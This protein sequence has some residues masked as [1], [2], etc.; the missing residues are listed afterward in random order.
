MQRQDCFYRAL[1]F[2]HAKAGFWGDSGIEA[3]VKFTYLPA[4]S[5]PMIK[6]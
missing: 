1:E 2:N 5:V 6:L 4:R 3:G